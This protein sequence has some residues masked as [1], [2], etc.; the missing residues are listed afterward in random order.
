MEFKTQNFKTIEDD[1][2]KIMDGFGTEYVM[3]I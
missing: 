2:C 1:V 3:T